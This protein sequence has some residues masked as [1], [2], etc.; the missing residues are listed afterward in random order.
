MRRRVTPSPATNGTCVQARSCARCR[1]ASRPSVPLHRTDG[2]RGGAQPQSGQPAGLLPHGRRLTEQAPLRGAA[3][4]P[5]SRPQYEMRLA[6]RAPEP[7]AA[8]WSRSSGAGATNWPAAGVDCC[9]QTPSAWIPIPDLRVEAAGCPR[10]RAAAPSKAAPA[11]RRS[12]APAPANQPSAARCKRRWLDPYREIAINSRPPCA[13]VATGTAPASDARIRRRS[14][15]VVR[16]DSRR[17]ELPQ[18]WRTRR[19]ADGGR[20]GRVN[21]KGEQ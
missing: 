3:L 9:S 21:E 10:R 18:G 8:H 13:V 1:Q 6:R 2:G 5:D 15:G 17:R 11:C 16:H 4:R 12:A 14:R 19:M 7:G 20:S